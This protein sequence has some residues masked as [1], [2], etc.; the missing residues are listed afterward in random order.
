MCFEILKNQ[1]KGKGRM[2]FRKGILENEIQDSLYN[3]IISLYIGSVSN[4]LNGSNR[5][6]RRGWNKIPA[7]K[8]GIWDACLV[9]IGKES[10]LNGLLSPA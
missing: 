4:E 10:A 8:K 2:L 9:L 1:S 5:N 3:N 7:K 6:E